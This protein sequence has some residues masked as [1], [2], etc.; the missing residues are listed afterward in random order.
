MT[1]FLYPKSDID[2]TEAALLKNDTDTIP[3][4]RPSLSRRPTRKRSVDDINLSLSYTMEHKI[5]DAVNPTTTTTID[6]NEILITKS[7]P[8]Q[9][10]RIS[11]ID[12]YTA[13][14]KVQKVRVRK[15]SIYSIYY[16]WELANYIVKVGDDVRQEHFAM[17]LLDE[18]NQIFIKKKLKLK[19]TPYEILPVGPDAC[20]VEMIQNAISFD[21]LK[22]KLTKSMNRKVSLFEYFGLYYNDEKKL[23]KARKNFCY[24]LAAYSLYCYF[25]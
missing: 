22:K 15:N 16:T 1:P 6:N 13:N 14:Q 11:A 7:P 5:S 24:S 17:Q 9:K 21:G 20:L 3:H 25:L 4:G 23:K 12:F 18:F 8:L 19:L 10:N 2:E